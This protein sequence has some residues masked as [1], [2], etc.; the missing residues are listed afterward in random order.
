MAGVRHVVCWRSE[1][2]DGTASQFA[3]DFYESLNQQHPSHVKDYAC[4]FRHAIFRMRPYEGDT[5]AP[6]R[7]F[8]AGAVNCVC[9]LSQNGDACPNSGRHLDLNK[10]NVGQCRCQHS[11]NVPA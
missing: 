1:V 3:L 5:R 9:L 7:H 2:E 8:S 11:Q 10:G 6:Q 4:I